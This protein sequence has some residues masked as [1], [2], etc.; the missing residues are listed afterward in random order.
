MQLTADGQLKHFLT[1]EGLPPLLLED[2]L[3][4][5]EQFVTVPNKQQKKAPLLRGKTVMNL[6]F[7]NSTRTALPLKLPRNAS[8]RMSLTSIF[9]PLQPPKGKPCWTRSVTLRR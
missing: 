2:I 1:V 9:V 7:E 6:F 8:A 4:R 3:K 5:A